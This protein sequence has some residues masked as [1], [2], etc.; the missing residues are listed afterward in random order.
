MDLEKPIR[1]LVARS[2]MAMDRKDFAAFLDMCELEFNYKITAYSPEIRRDMLWLEK[3]KK[4]LQDLLEILPKQNMDKTPITR[5]SALLTVDL[6]E[7][8]NTAEVV[9]SLQVY[10]TELDGGVTTLYAVGKYI[11]RVR[12]NGGAPKLL[13]REVR[14][15]TRM[16]GAGYHIPF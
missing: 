1:E 14:L 9:S 5:H 10:R 11:D 8:S 15:D 16:L 2:C 4:G 3:D 7:P 6:D 12:L 13:S